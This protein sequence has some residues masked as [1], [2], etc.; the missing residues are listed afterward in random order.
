MENNFT[1]INNFTLMGENNLQ[2][3]VV[4]LGAVGFFICGGLF[5]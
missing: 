1:N 2:S 4:S 3:G 5:F